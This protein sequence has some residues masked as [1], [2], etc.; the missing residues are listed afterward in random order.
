MTILWYAI[1]IFKSSFIFDKDFF[2]GHFK[3]NDKEIL[4]KVIINYLQTLMFIK[5]STP[6][7]LLI[8]L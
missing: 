8:E 4:I 7:G 6:K 5:S 1:D 3:Y 2:F